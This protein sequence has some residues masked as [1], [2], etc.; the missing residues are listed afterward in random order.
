MAAFNAWGQNDVYQAG[1]YNSGTAVT[2]PTLITLPAALKFDAIF[3]DAQSNTLFA[4]VV[5]TPEPSVGLLAATFGTLA[6]R[7]RRGA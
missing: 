5:A 3:A 6:R 2:R 4:S 7:R 1:V